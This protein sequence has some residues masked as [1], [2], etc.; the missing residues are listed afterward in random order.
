MLQSKLVEVSGIANDAWPWGN[1]WGK[2]V[3]FAG[4]ATPGYE[5]R[6]DLCGTDVPAKWDF[7]DYV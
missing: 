5:F 6:P 7:G 3:T 1:D 4:G 2:P